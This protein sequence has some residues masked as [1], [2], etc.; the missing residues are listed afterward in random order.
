MMFYVA[1]ISTGIMR[2]KENKGRKNLR[3]NLIN[4]REC[5]M[6][7]VFR[8][9]RRGFDGVCGYNLDIKLHCLCSY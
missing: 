1:E 5:V 6:A 9:W 3:C 4:E 8:G 7:E 2:V